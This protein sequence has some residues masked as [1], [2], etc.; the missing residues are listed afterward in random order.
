M[1]ENYSQETEEY[2]D[3]L[4]KGVR[5]EYSVAELAR[6]KGLDP[7][8][9]VEIPLAMTLA[10]KCVGLISTVYPQLGKEVSDRILELEKEYGQLDTAVSFKIAE[11]VAKEKFCK[12]KDQMEAIDAGIRVGFAYTTLGVVSSPIEGF[13]GIKIGK[14]KEGKDY[15][16]AYFSGPIRSAGTTAGC[17]ALMLIDYLRECFGYAK[18]DPNEKE[19][20]RYVTESFDYHE[21]ITNLQYLPTEEEITFL[22]QNLPIQI[23]GDPT[24]K[25]EVSN[26]K[27][28]PRVETNTIRGGMCL[29]LCE[30]LAQKA[31]KGYRLYNSVKARGFQASGW[32]F[33]D[34]YI[35]IHKK[36]EK[37]TVDLSPTYLKDMVA[38]RPVFGHPSASGGFRFRYG[39]SRVAGFSATS[40]HPATMAISG[41][42]L[43]YGNQLKIERP[44]KG[45]V[46]SSCDSIDGPIV[47]LSDGSVRKLE[48]FEEAKKLYKDTI[49]ILYFGDILFPL[50]DV[51]NR[52]YELLRAG[53]VEEWWQLELDKK[54][55]EK[56]EELII[57]D[58][59]KISLDMAIELSKKYEI[60]LH[61]NFIFYWNQIKK[62]E[63]LELL[64]FLQ[65]ATWRD[66]LKEKIILPYEQS[67]RERFGVA[68][69][70]LEILGVEHEIVMDNIVINK[71][72]ALL[73]NLGFYK[74]DNI[75][76]NVLK[77]LVKI[78]NEIKD[79]ENVL[80]LVNLFSKI[81]IKDKTGTFIGSR[82][83]R[84]EKA[85]LRKLT[86]SPNVLFPVGEQGGRMRSF[87]EAVNQGNVKSEFP[88]FY[89]DKCKKE[90]IYPLCEICNSPLKK[91]YYCNECGRSLNE[92]CEHEKCCTY[93]NRKIDIKYYLQK[94]LDRLGMTRT[95][96]PELIKGIRGTSNSEHDMEDLAKGILRAKYSI[97][98]NKDGTIRYDAT[99]LP[100]THFKPKEIGTSVI[101][102]KELGY[103]KDLYGKELESE[104]QILEIKP[105]DIILPSCPETKD[106]RADDVFFN[107]ANFI[108]E[109]LEKF[110]H[111]PRF[112][113]LKE[114]KDLVGQLV[115]CMAPHN[116]AGVIG[117]IIGNAKPQGLLASPYMHAAMRRD[118]FDYNT[119][120]PIKEGNNWKIVKIGEYVEKLNPQKVVDNWGTKEKKVENVKTLGLNKDLEEVKINNFTKHTP[121]RFLEIKT[122]LGKEIKVTENHKFLI[123]GKEIRA[124]NLKEGDKLPLIY[125]ISIKPQD[126]EEF[127]LI[128]L[129]KEENLMISN[130]KD[131][132]YGLD[133]AHLLKILEDLNISKRQFSNYNL[134][135]CYP[136]SFVLKLGE[137]T[138]EKVYNIGKISSKRDRVKLPIK[139]KLTN[140][141]LEVIGLYIAEGYS[142][143]ISGKKG[144]NQVYIASCEMEIRNFVRKVFFDSFGLKP[145]E[146]KEDR[147]T[148]SS[149]ILYLLFNKVLEVGSIAKEKRIPS[150][151]LSLPLEKLA[152]ILRGYFEGD[153]FAE[154]NRKKISCDSV[155]EG[156]LYDLEF[157]LAR[158][159]IFAKRY[160]YK[161][162]PGKRVKEFYLRK[163]RR[164]PEFEIT[165]LIIG[166]D[167]VDKFE[168]IGFLS[169]RKN[170]IIEEYKKINEYGMRIKYDN[171]FVYDPIISIKKLDEGVS[172]CLNVNTKNHLVVA[173]SILNFQCDGDEAAIMLL[174]DVLINFSRKFLPAHRGGTQDAPLVLNSR[175]RAGEVDDQI[176]DLEMVSSYPLELYELAEQGKH[177]SEIKIDNV[178]RRLKEGRDNF[179]NTGFTHDTTNFNECVVNS[180][181]KVFPSMKEKVGKEMELCSKLRSVNAA[182]VAR[183]I[184]ERHFIRDIRGNLRKFSMQE[185]RCVGCNEKFR[186]PP[187]IGVCTK[188]G[189]K[190][191]FTISEGSI[192]KYLEPALDLANNFA[193]PAYTKQGLELAKIYIQSIF[194][195]DETKQVEL[196]K[197]F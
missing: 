59:K 90:T 142:R 180:S 144:L 103:K 171:N 94:A 121:I 110:Y 75:K 4:V 156:L 161:K 40:I 191:I 163:N 166:S 46:I 85:K 77:V 106:E 113:N 178:K 188:C 20:K 111:L 72:S 68:K 97:T 118:C 164:V 145:S 109:L 18:Y 82:M 101:K 162:E 13:T 78:D 176:L 92:K 99:E 88:L 154:R 6:Q 117:R 182:D 65:Y 96:L 122:S 100:I 155:S 81:K 147:V 80:E 14:T 33:L 86:G 70:A 5:E 28:I 12:F 39:R 29:I 158:F 140:S 173:N 195:K 35:E 34:K 136:L 64:E 79:K 193:V 22:A 169:E 168:K 55:K 89:C 26:Y 23:N 84:P 181:Y 183:L 127:N 196:K 43:S 123:N 189:G 179:T 76:E 187:M 184:I 31:Q 11:E 190:I 24:E 3:K 135:D 138:R 157:C 10:E 185:F 95:E 42:F 7:V 115:V 131:I 165:K 74:E 170:L 107:A 21:R 8:N 130:I 128:E 105:H 174:L 104:E 197:W 61:P 49:E 149:K 45:C 116:C 51:I 30:G 27:D 17:V 66:E 124:S 153:G 38:G 25:L 120:L 41:N 9:K 186:R 148:F 1:V 37:G 56:G 73:F 194:G 150:L 129:L 119:Y 114:K 192:V 177:S 91:T 167:F 152:C 63:F 132:V 159:G 47:K 16:I 93:S 48:N 71:G 2:F 102:L 62:I 172:Y 54:A 160:K 83:G 44:T 139:I 125:N 53:Y 69:R 67:I 19:V 151:F 87:Q 146:R 36:R 141:L 57:V 15:F 50:G 143:S 126:I 134:R 98:V 32:D 133:K 112:Y 52:N 108:D 58:H 137:K 175:I 60:P